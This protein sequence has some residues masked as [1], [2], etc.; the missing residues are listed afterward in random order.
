MD[1]RAGVRETDR[2]AAMDNLDFGYAQSKWVAEQLV[3]DARHEGARTF[4]YRPSFIS[5]STAGVASADDIVV[6]LL[7]FMIN[8]RIAVNALNQV[9]FLPADVV[10][11]NIASIV[12]DPR[13]PAGTAGTVHVTA[14]DYYNLMDVTRILTRAYGCMSS[15]IS[16]F[17]TSSPS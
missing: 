6:R 2:N 3:L 14:D 17:R 11:H 1:G 10:A 15:S 9:S 8:K 16:T 13:R 7:A 4:V 12:C 5:A